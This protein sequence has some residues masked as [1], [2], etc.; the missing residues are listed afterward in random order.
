M[1]SKGRGGRRYLARVFTEQGVAMLSG[2]LRSR[3]AVDVNVAIMR[4]F[5]HLRELLATHADLARKL[6]ELERKYDGQFVAVFDAIRDLMTTPQP[7]QPRPRIG[8]VADL[9][10]E[11]TNSRRSAENSL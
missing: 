1:T 11:L 5:V 10:E 4:A 9:R 8:F 7:E 3:R 2:V 6:E